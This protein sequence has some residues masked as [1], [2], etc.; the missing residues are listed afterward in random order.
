[1]SRKR[2]IEDRWDL[3]K[4]QVTSQRDYFFDRYQKYGDHK[5]EWFWMNWVL[6]TMDKLERGEPIE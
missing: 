6:K 3:L 2:R 1:M 5:L 4:A